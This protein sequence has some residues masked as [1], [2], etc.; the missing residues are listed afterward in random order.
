MLK[1]IGS[2]IKGPSGQLLPLSAGIEVDGTVYLSGQLALCDGR[3]V[4]DDIG[5]QTAM[6]LANIE[7]ILATADLTLQDIFKASIWLTRREDF[8]AF[9]AVFASK[10]SEPYPVRSTVVS[11]L[12][13]DGALIE[14][15]V[16]ATRSRS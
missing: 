4:G 15:E 6:I 12:V 2:P 10:F 16:T 8:P 11:D 13:V 1:Q 7:T 3:I 5:E 14:I 9:N